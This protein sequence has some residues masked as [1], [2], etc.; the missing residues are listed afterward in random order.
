MK[1]IQILITVPDGVDVKVGGSA[2]QG[3]SKPFVERPDP[4]F[5]QSSCPECGS[6]NWRLIKAGYSKTKKNEDGTPKRF[7]A[8]YV[9]G[10][11]N[12]DGKPGQ[13]MAME[14]VSGDQLPF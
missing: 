4:G 3:S 14:D 6:S 7:N 5:P 10:T 12:C 1:T 13:E 11:D 8:F 2:Q 9:C